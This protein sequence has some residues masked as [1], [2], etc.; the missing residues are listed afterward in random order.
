MER[1]Q[2]MVS[3]VCITY[4]QVSYIEKAIKSFLM[5][6]TN[7]KFEIIIHDDASS[8][9]TKDILKKYSSLFPDKIIL[10]LQD[11][12]QYSQGINIFNSY[13]YPIVRGKYIALCEGDDFWTD[14]NKLQIQFNYMENNSGCKLCIHDAFF[15]TADEKITFNSKPLSKNPINYGI[16]DAIMGIGIKVATNSFFYTSEI[17]K[18]PMTK[19]EI[20]SPSGDFPLAI[21][22]SLCGYIHYMPKKMCAHR[23][24]AKNSFSESMSKGRESINKWFIFLDKLEDS[25]NELDSYTNFKFSSIIK[26]SLYKQ[27]FNIYLL[28]RNKQKLKSE[29]FNIMF[30]K[31]SFKKKF[32]YYTPS[33]FNLLQRIHYFFLRLKTTPIKL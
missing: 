22:L 31:I 33:I 12:N 25:M 13:I 3:V 21:T 15:I 29:P 26:N 5:Q 4:N 7:F 11:K 1:E 24:L 30:K 16:E 10:I 6:K 17:V 8:D 23:M 2:I 19:F 27:K 20:L 18:K 14:S 28:T 9:G 32:E